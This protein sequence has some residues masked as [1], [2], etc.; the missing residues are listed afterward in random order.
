MLILAAVCVHG[1]EPD[2]SP[3]VARALQQKKGI[4]LLTATEM[5]DRKN[6]DPVYIEF[7]PS[8]LRDRHL[9]LLC[10]VVTTERTFASTGA[11][12]PKGMVAAGK[13][14]GL[15][16]RGDL[17][18]FEGDQIEIRAYFPRQH[19]NYKTVLIPKKDVEYMTF[20]EK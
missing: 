9:H 2:S 15:V 7:K 12:P 6:G 14:G 16:Y 19:D 18:S 8:D 17:Y 3:S 4:D 13:D 20:P 11:W 10:E 1:Q 5:H